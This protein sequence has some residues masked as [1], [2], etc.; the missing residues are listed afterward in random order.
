MKKSF[1]SL[2][3]EGAS[4]K[5][6]FRKQIRTLILFTLGFT[7]A[8]TWRQTIFDISLDLVSFFTHIKNSASL[9]ILASILVT[10]LCVLSIYFTS[11][12]LRDENDRF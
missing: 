3:V 1:S 11:K 9:S 6:E 4:F 8:F 10:F 7:I 2:F 5:K 12:W